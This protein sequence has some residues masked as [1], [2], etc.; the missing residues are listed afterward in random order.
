MWVAITNHMMSAQAPS[1][2]PSQLFPQRSV[3]W[4]GLGLSVRASNVLALANC[5]TVD[6]IRR[7]GRSYFQ[8]RRNCGE[9]TLNELAQ[10]AGWTP[11]LRTPVDA[12][13]AAL[14][15]TIRDPEEAREAAFDVLSSLRR[16]GFVM[17]A[18]KRVERAHA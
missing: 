16:S 4:Q 14:S 11:K 1:P 18:S 10:L 13:A 15:L 2:R 7:L 5:Q 12:I 9:H 6:D 8:G 17:A 3:T